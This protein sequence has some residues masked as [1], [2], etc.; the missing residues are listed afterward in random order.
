MNI[1]FDCQ[2]VLI[3]DGD[4]PAII[5]TRLRGK[6]IPDLVNHLV[7]G[8][9]KIYIVS[10]APEAHP[11]AYETL[12]KLMLWHNIPNHGIYPVFHKPGD[13]PYE[14]GKLKAKAMEEL[15]CQ[16]IFDD[17]ME[18]IRGVRDSGKIGIHYSINFEKVAQ[19]TV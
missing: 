8:G 17:N 1:A 14:I 19:L 10:A 15:D 2:G 9:A 7:S 4:T 6:I 18:V 12:V 3:D 13:S 11:L 16:I 5:E